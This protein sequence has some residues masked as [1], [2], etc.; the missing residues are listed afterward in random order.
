MTILL[1]RSNQS[2]IYNGKA[3]PLDKKAFNKLEKIM[4]YCSTLYIIQYVLRLVERTNGN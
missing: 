4:Q 2:L 1:N 3:I